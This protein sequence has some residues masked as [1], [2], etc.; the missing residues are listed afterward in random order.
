MKAKTAKPLASF[1]F[2]HPYHL[3]EGLYWTWRSSDWKNLPEPGGTLDQDR[4]LLD[5][6]LTYHQLYCAA[7]DEVEGRTPT[8]GGAILYDGL[9]Q[10]KADGKRR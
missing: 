6:M 4:L 1:G 9:K 10:R 5:D 2:H 3:V 7:E 8:D